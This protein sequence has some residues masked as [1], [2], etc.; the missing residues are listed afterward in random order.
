MKE[1]YLR[2]KCSDFLLFVVL[3]GKHPIHFLAFFFPH[4]LHSYLYLSSAF[5]Q[6]L[7]LLL[8]VTEALYQ[9]FLGNQIFVNYV[10]LLNV[11]NLHYILHETFKSSAIFFL[12]HERF[13]LFSLHLYFQVF[14]L[15]VHLQLLIFFLFTVQFVP[16][17][18]PMK[19][20]LLCNFNI[21]LNLCH[22]PI[23]QVFK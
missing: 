6:L 18:F 3:Y 9:V 17:F 21:R 10:A 15:Y 11:N 5:F 7:I 16:L 4:L 13:F 20:V 2:L 1:F 8:Q 19:L 14:L 23:L 22:G 12:N